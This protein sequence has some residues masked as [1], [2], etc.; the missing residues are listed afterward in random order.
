MTRATGAAKPTARARIARVSAWRGWRELRAAPCRFWGL[1]AFLFAVLAGGGLFVVTY[2]ASSY[3]SEQQV[4]AQALVSSVAVS[5][6]AHLRGALNPSLA[7]ATFVESGPPPTH[8]SV[9]NW[10]T[11]AA[12]ALVMASP[13]IDDV[14]IAPCGHVAAVYPLVSARRNA[15]GILLGGG[16]DLF[17]ASSIIANRRQAA[18]LALTTRQ[19]HIEGP[20]NIL[21]PLTTCTASCKYG[22][23]ALLSRIPLFASTTAA[24]DPWSLGYRWAAAPG[25]PPLGPFTNVTGCD[26]VRSAATGASLCDT[27]ATGDGRRFWGFFTIIVMWNQLLELAGVERLGTEYKWSIARSVETSDGT[28]AF[29]LVVVSSSDGSLPT[30]AYNAGAVSNVVRAYSSAWVITIEPRTGSLTPVLQDGAIAGVVVLAVLITALIVFIALQQQLNDNL[31]YSMLPRRIVSMLRA[32]EEH[33]AEHFE[34]V[35]L[36]FTDIVRFT[37]LVG[38]ITPHETMAMLNDLFMDFDEIAQRHGVTKLETVGDAFVG[39]AGISG[40]RDP[41]AQALQIARCALEMVECAGRHE[42]PNSGN[43]LIRVGLHCGPAVGGVV[44]RTLPHYSLFG[45]TIN[46]TARMESN[47]L[48][49]RI[50]VSDKF[51]AAFV[52][53]EA[54]DEAAAAAAAASGAPLPPPLPFYLQPRG[55]VEIKGKGVMETHFLLRRGDAIPHGELLGPSSPQRTFG[56]STSNNSRSVLKTA[57][58]SPVDIEA[59][60][61]TIDAL[62]LP[63][64]GPLLS[65]LP[66]LRATKG[67]PRLTRSAP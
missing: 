5:F 40:E 33:I 23:S 14:Q 2:F 32:G 27:N 55:A 56:S 44:G 20:K 3:A 6:G 12:P 57:E 63:T 8:E 60:L 28:G 18:I 58:S 25:G 34:H 47:S 15:T 50:H 10:F 53:A 9:Q 35:T 7:V 1:A 31:L 26:V 37:D 16:H 41:R 29:P 61:I 11:R 51:A 38:T 62:A 17:N 65:W 66:A 21:S 30:S 13:A 24:A 36:L 52:A 43:M 59:T 4:R 39:V 42:L 22:Q 54:A 67:A 45:D 46:T 48:P 49:G 64:P 19:L